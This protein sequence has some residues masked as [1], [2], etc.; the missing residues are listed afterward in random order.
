MQPED[1]FVAG[2]FSHGEI[3]IQQ[4]DIIPVSPEELVNPRG[5]PDGIY[6]F[7]LILEQDPEGFQDLGI[8]IDNEDARR[9]HS[10]K[11]ICNLRLFVRISDTWCS[12]IE[13]FLSGLKVW[14]KYN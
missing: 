14:Y 13:H 5:F 1:P 7:K 11:F 2:G 9:D 6:G 3:H 4:Q 8:V 10:R 12:V